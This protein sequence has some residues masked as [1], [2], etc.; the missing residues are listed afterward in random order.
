MLTLI[1]IL[2]QRR[3]QLLEFFAWR[4]GTKHW[5][6]PLAYSTGLPV[7]L[8]AKIRRFPVAFAVEDDPR[9]AKHCTPRDIL[10]AE[11]AA[12]HLGFRPGRVISTS[13]KFTPPT[14]VELPRW[15]DKRIKWRFKRW[16]K[17][18]KGPREPKPKGRESGANFHR[19]KN[20]RA[21][22][23]VY[24]KRQD[25]QKTTVDEVPSIGERKGSE[26]SFFIQSDQIKTISGADPGSERIT[27][28]TTSDCSG[29]TT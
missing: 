4:F 8:I 6:L 2:E 12:L 1:D 28:L 24:K 16:L 15:A 11:Q 10:R 25:G 14:S 19:L 5:V 13:G 23:E 21:D 26:L 27:N 18:T 3:L 22:G 20:E 29:P 9:S 17:D 7:W